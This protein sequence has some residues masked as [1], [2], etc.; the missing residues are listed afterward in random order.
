M[1]THTSAKN[2]TQYASEDEILYES[3]GNGAHNSIM[4]V[5]AQTDIVT[6][7]QFIPYFD[8]SKSVRLIENIFTKTEC[9]E[10]LKK[11]MSYCRMC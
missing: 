7:Q 6:H 2:T 3:E 5:R 10:M 8:V 1:E 9:V 11:R 4:D